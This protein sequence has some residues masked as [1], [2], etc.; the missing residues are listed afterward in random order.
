MTA[1]DNPKHELF[2]QLI[3]EGKSQVMAY[4]DAGFSGN[5]ARGNASRLIANDSIKARIKALQEA[6]LQD[7]KENTAKH[8]SEINGLITKA[9]Q[10]GQYHAAIKGFSIK[11]KLLD[12]L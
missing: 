1:L 3:V 7:A 2:A 4:I 5:G 11:M 6:N 10:M 12:I 8:L 9:G